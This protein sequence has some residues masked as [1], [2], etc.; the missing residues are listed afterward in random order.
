MT[1]VVQIAILIVTAAILVLVILA[2]PILIDLRRITKEWKRLSE[3]VGLGLAPVT[4]VMSLAVNAFKKLSE[5]GEE[6]KKDGLQK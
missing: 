3:I 1:T 2:I 5:I 4:W 6:S